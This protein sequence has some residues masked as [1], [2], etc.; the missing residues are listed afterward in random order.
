MSE[1]D[2]HDEYVRKY[3]FLRNNGVSALM[4]GIS[5]EALR[6]IYGLATRRQPKYS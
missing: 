1:K 6:R 2:S 5:L 4:H 3:I